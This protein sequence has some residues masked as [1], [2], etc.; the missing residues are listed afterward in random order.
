V[1]D[2]TWV[3]IEKDSWNA[4]DIVLNTLL[5]KNEAKKKDR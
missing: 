1:T 4:D 3:D 2:F 5:K